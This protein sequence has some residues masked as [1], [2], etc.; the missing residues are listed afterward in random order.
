MSK[1]SGSMDSIGKKGEYAWLSFVL[2]IAFAVGLSVLLFNWMSGFAS[3][4]SSDIKQRV[5]TTELCDNLAISLDVC[6]NQSSPQN[7]YINV[8]NR[9]D[10]RVNQLFFH[11]QKPNGDFQVVEINSSIRPGRMERFNSTDLNVTFDTNYTEVTPSTFRDNFVITCS[12]RKAVA[13]PVFC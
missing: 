7:L 9:G 3:D 12:G 8:T 4:S 13:A 1:K 6:K 11:I 10:I 5:I 2:L